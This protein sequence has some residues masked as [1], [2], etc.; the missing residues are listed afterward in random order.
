MSLRRLRPY[1]K[2]PYTERRSVRFQVESG[3]ADDDKCPTTGQVGD[4]G[5]AVQGIT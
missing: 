4:R 5:R 1:V 2:S 3:F